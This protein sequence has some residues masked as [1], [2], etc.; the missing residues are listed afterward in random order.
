MKEV[1]KNK[2]GF[3]ADKIIEVYNDEA[4]RGNILDILGDRLS[5]AKFVSPED[6]IFIFFAG[7]GITRE[8]PAGGEMGYLVPID[9]DPERIHSTCISMTEIANISRLIPAKHVLFVIDTC[10]GGL[11]GWLSSR[12]ISLSEQ[13]IAYV[14]KKTK[15]RGR[16]LISAG[17]K[18]EEVYESD[19][20]GH[21]VFIYYLLRGLRGSA[22]LNN[23]GVITAS[24]LYQY[25]E[26]LVSNE[27]NQKQTPQFR[28]LPAEGE[29]EFVFIVENP[30]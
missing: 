14:E 19:I 30:D 5:N 1:L 4:T 25:V 26:P 29:G 8:L 12:R 16:Q 21:S 3:S 15:E 7:H 2:L 11:V 20:W 18:D 13:T 6:R 24:E 28:Y 27:T 10:Y 23:D 22:D 9:G 17:Q